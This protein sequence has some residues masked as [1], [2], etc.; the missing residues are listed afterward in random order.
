M[1]AHLL[2]ILVRLRSPNKQF[3]QTLNAWHFWFALA[4]VLPSNAE[5]KSVRFGLLNWALGAVKKFLDLISSFSLAVRASFSAI[6][7][8]LPKF[9]NHSTRK[10]CQ[11]LRVASLAFKGGLLLVSLAQIASS[12][13]V[14]EACLL[15]SISP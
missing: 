8:Y 14:L 9:L 5:S 15:A 3:K 1:W 7:L 11:G 6:W 13:F 2:I 10:T 4:F 12:L